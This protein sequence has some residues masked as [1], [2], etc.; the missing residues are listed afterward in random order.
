MRGAG[1]KGLSAMP[2]IKPFAKGF[3]GRPL[4]DV[5]KAMIESYASEHTLQWIEDESNLNVDFSRNFLR[6]DILPLLKKRWPSVADTLSRVAEHCSD[7]QNFIDN[8]MDEH[9]ASVKSGAGLSISALLNLPELSQRYVL[10]RWFSILRFPIPSV[11]KMQQIQQSLLLAAEDKMPHIMWGHVELRRYQDTLYAM[12]KLLKHDEQIIY[13]WDFKQDLLLPNVGKLTAHVVMGQGLRCD[14]TSVTVRFRQGGECCRL[15]GR[16]FHHDLKKLFQQWGV[17]P[18]E[19]A[20]IPLLFAEDKL[21]AVVGY[22]I[23]SEYEAKPSENGLA[24]CL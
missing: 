3:H 7:A 12:Q 23:D 11:V 2:S 17:P 24:L 16:N 6:H 13:T 22:Y 5:P 15:P 19:R 21:I 9:L 4:L 8:A 20:R 18:W 10:R 14:I 1:P